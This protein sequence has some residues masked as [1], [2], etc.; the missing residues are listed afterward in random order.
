MDEEFDGL[1]YIASYGDLI[2]AFGENTAAGENHYERSGRAERRQTD[3][4]DEAQ[5]LANYPDLQ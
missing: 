3:A 4:F 1:Q 5:Y 2:Q